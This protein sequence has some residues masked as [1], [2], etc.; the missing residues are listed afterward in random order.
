MASPIIELL[1]CIVSP[2]WAVAVSGVSTGSLEG[3]LARPDLWQEYQLLD[4]L[5][6]KN[7]NQHHG[8][9]HFH[10]LQEVRR[11]LKLL[12][13]MH[14][15]QRASSF[16][17][18][19]QAAK[20]RGSL[21][22]GS[23]LMAQG[24]DRRQV[25]S[26]SAAAA[27]LGT[28]RAACHLVEQLA[29]AVH[30]ASLQLLAQLAH[31]FFMP[32]CLTSLA[33]I[34]R[35]QVLTGQTVLDAVRAYNLVAEVAVLLPDSPSTTAAAGT[36]T[37]AA[38]AS[39]VS[40]QAGLP[41]EQQL[42]QMLRAQWREG[43]PLIEAVPCSEADGSLAMQ[44][45]AA[46]ARY[47]LRL[48]QQQ[49]ELAGAEPGLDTVVP[50]QR[51]QGRRQGGKPVPHPVLAVLEDRGVP[52]SREAFMLAPLA[53]A[54]SS[55][56]AEQAASTPAAAGAASD[57][58][59]VAAEVSSAAPA[60]LLGVVEDSMP[61]VDPSGVVASLMAGESRGHLY[62]RTA[63]SLGG[64]PQQQHPEQQ[65]PQQRSASA[66][67]RKAAPLPGGATG[68]SAA[69]AVGRTAVAEV[70]EGGKI[71]SVAARPESA[72]ATS[73][74][75]AHAPA[76]A[77]VPA[78]ALVV[79]KPAFLSVSIAPTKPALLTAA[80]PAS[81]PAFLSVAATQPAKPA[82]LAVGP[83]PPNADAQ[84]AVE[85]PSSAGAAPTK[86]VAALALD[87]TSRKRKKPAAAGAAAE[88]QAAAAAEAAAAPKS[89]QD[90]LEP[91][92]SAAAA[93]GQ[94]LLPSGKQ[95]QPREQYSKQQSKRQ[96]HQQ[97]T[98][99]RMGR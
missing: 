14:L 16:H 23:V 70:S 91:V 51:Q 98:R 18:A 79:P 8:S 77:E 89:W 9:Q 11:L 88:Q 78:A 21:P 52:I 58:V 44:A 65:Q 61:E 41:A 93:G 17:A 27:L 22:L 2:E 1:P 43:L 74:P 49:Q 66:K 96:Q 56:G 85:P 67:R 57:S 62:R 47:G 6:Y 95:Q 86:P 35:I 30:R 68:K 69:A 72:V 97:N 24:G 29:P 34:A 48:E 12:K 10:A 45:A 25:P 80:V 46:C 76:P 3:A 82:F 40:S 31:S 81:K 13:S 5:L 83:S 28:L 42:P 20:Q 7:A 59:A 92:P 19:F 4:K 39:R 50:H 90:W 37:D 73:A 54:A 60:L 36:G 75:A 26:Y 71:A 53:A 32:L 87:V 33:V 84:P 38:P 99:R 64:G 15:E 94:P 63:A 55:G